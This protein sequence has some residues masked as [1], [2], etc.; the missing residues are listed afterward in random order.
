MAEFAFC[1]TV[2]PNH[3]SFDIVYTIC[4]LYIVYA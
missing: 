1:S 4:N 3:M 2:I